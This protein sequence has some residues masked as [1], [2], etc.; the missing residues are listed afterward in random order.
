M[1]LMDQDGHLVSDRCVAELHRFAAA[2]GLKGIWFQGAPN[3]R[4]P[5][6]DMTALWRKSLAQ[7]SGARLVTTREI[8]R[9]AVRC[10]CQPPPS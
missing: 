7:R 1:I 3:H 8:V 5:H 6:Y 4:M 9:R 2:I 10:A